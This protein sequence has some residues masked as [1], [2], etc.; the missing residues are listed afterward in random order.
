[1]P[2][3][4]PYSERTTRLLTKIQQWEFHHPE[5]S[6]SWLDI[7]AMPGTLNAL[8]AAGAI[9]IVQMEAPRRYRLTDMARTI[10]DPAT[11]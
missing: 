8:I 2:L 4:I 9:E 7:Q 11:E 5:Q 1:M 6:W 10:I 3:H